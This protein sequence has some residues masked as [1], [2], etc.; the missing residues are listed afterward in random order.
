MIIGLTGSFCGGKDSAA[1]YLGEKGFKHFSLSDIIRDECRKKKKKLTRTN[2]QKIGIELREKFG[3]T[4]LAERALKK[5]GDGKDYI[6]TSIRHP[7]EVKALMKDKNFF[8]VKVDAPVRVRFER[9]AARKREEDPETFEKFLKL[10]GMEMEGSGSG[11]RIRECNEMA[12]IIL[13]NDSSFDVLKEKVDKMV[14]DLKKKIVK[15]ELKPRPSWDEYFMKIA[16]LVGE[17]STCVRHHVGAIAVKGK[18]VLATGYN[19]AVA[20]TKDCLELGCLRNELGIAS[21]TRHEICRAIHA[22]QNVVVQAAIHGISIKD[23][24]I[25]CT[26]SPCIL[27]AKILANAKIKEVVTFSEYA[28]QSFKELFKEAGI[29]FR[30]IKKPEM[31]ISFLE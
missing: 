29:K 23:A 31:E 2:L 10:E 27:C 12:K 28:D 17:R 6:I 16:T 3:D 8:L 25:Y 4:V 15:K 5:A 7:D 13:V 21:G 14:N 20:G 30:K 11:Q 19:G 9:M 22:E 26:H 1:E 24:T 18:R